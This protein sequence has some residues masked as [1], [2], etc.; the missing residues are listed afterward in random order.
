MDPISLGL[1]VVGLGMQLFG[2]FGASSAA[3]Q[4][5]QLSQGI[6]IDEQA[7]N[8]QKQQQMQLEARRSQLQNFRNA[9]RLRAQATSAAVQGGAQFGSGL[10]GGLGGISGTET[11]NALGI[12]QGSQI[13]QNIF[14]FNNDISSKRIQS[15]QLGG[16]I[17]TDQGLSSLG[18]ALVKSGPTIGG[19]SKDVGAWAKGG[20]SFG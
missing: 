20:F 7:I 9:Q 4:Q 19:L 15:A 16:Q 5:A 8:I 11:E 10:P 17:A 12:N 13:S 14:G 3:K 18:G 1:G 6:G 2:G